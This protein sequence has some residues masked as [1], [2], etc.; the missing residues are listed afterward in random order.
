MFIS[1]VT[2]AELRYGAALAAWGERRLAQ[3]E[4]RITV[5][6]IVW[7]GEGLVDAYVALRHESIVAGHPLGRRFMRLIVGSLPPPAG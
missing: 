6:E 4:A 1:F 7:A 5:A 3:L 2:V